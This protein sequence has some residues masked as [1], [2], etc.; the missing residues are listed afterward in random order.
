MNQL[1]QFNWFN[2]DSFEQSKKFSHTNQILIEPKIELN[3]KCYLLD[4]SVFSWKKATLRILFFDQHKRIRN[5]VMSLLE[6]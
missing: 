2:S 1:N 3:Q 6:E 4:L 5:Q